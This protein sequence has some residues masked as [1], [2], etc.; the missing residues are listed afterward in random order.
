MTETYISLNQGEDDL[1]QH[2]SFEAIGLYLHLKKKADYIAVLIKQ[3]DGSFRK[4]PFT[5]DNDD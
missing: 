3:R 2:L 5:T 4:E 1:F